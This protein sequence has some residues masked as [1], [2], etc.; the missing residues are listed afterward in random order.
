[1]PTSM[2]CF[3]CAAGTARPAATRTIAVMTTIRL[4]NNRLPAE[5][6]Q[7][8]AQALL[9][10]DL[11]LPA[12]QLARAG[13]VGLAYLRIVHGQCLVDDVALRPRDP[14]DRLGEL[15]EGELVRIADVHGQMLAGLRQR[16][17]PADEVVHVTK[18]SCLGA[19][20]EHGERLSLERLPDKRRN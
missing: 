6:R 12:Q 1:M 20:P 4:G 11:R 9:Q 16:N 17:E 15:I 14:D 5:A 18:A 13:D 2:C 8:P 3:A 10:V 7:H 19:V